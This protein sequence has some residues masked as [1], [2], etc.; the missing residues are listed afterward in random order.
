[1]A[2]PGRW[3]LQ[4]HRVGVVQGSSRPVQEAKEVISHLQLHGHTAAGD[5][6]LYLSKTCHQKRN[7]AARLAEIL[8]CA[9]QL[10][11]YRHGM[12][13]Q[14]QR[15]ATELVTVAHL[16]FSSL[17]V[18]CKCR[19]APEGVLRHNF[20]ETGRRQVLGIRRLRPVQQHLP[21]IAARQ[22]LSAS[23]PQRAPDITRSGQLGDRF[24]HC[25]ASRRAAA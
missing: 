17:T 9:V 3:E 4:K 14:R 13:W 1:M 25:S 11:H 10:S 20:H 2:C 12:A 6:A 15:N 18:S 19:C 7:K 22:R 24:A 21:C 23:R 8:D 16:Q 5:T